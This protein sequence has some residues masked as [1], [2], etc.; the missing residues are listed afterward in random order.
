MCVVC[1]YICSLSSLHCVQFHAS[2]SVEIQWSFWWLF[3]SVC[4][5]DCFFFISFFALYVLRLLLLGIVCVCVCACMV[6][7]IFLLYE[8]KIW[9]MPHIYNSFVFS[10]RT[11]SMPCWLVPFCFSS[12][13][14][15][16]FHF[17]CFDGGATHCSTHQFSLSLSLSFRLFHAFYIECVFSA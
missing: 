11:W 13:E 16:R 6:G 3:Y 4:F 17:I 10:L 15:I 12:S 2:I 1:I 9:L 5:A 7:C 8:K 14:I